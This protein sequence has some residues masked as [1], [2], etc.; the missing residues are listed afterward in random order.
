MLYDL[1]YINDCL[2]AVEEKFYRDRDLLLM[3]KI[4]FPLGIIKNINAEKY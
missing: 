4:T 3:F 1:S 2:R